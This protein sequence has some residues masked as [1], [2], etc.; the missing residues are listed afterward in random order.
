MRRRGVRVESFNDWLKSRF[1]LHHHAWHRGLDNNRTQLLGAILTYQ[2]LM[3]LNH[4]RATATAAFNGFSTPD[5]SRT[6][7]ASNLGLQEAFSRIALH[8]P[9][10]P[11]IQSM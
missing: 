10:R 2:L 6:P 9:T 3:H 5:N 7:S 11:V 1:D 4:Q 8:P